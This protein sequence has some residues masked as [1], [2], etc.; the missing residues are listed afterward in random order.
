MLLLQVKLNGI[1][2]ELGEVEAQLG[3]NAAVSVHNGK[4][5]AYVALAGGRSQPAPHITDAVRWQGLQMA[6]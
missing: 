2:V 4:L 3:A 1:R 5:V 6:V